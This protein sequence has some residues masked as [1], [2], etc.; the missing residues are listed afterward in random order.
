MDYVQAALALYE[1]YRNEENARSM[2]KYMRDQFKFF[3]M[4][5]PT[6]RAAEKEFMARCGLPA[7]DQWLAVLEELWNCE[8]REMQM[9]GLRMLDKKKKAFRKED[10]ALIELVLNRKVWWDTVDHTSKWHAGAYLMQFEAEKPAI[11]EKWLSSP[12]KWEVRAAILFQ[13][14]Y[15]G[16]T[17]EKILYENIRRHADSKEFFIAKAIGWALRE[18]AYTNPESVYE[19][20]QN[21]PMQPLSKRE[22]LKH[23]PKDA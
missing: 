4:R 6:M 11:L 15:K 22:A 17:Y 19:F 1:Q 3:G 23:F 2:E 8:E 12:N 10:L 13:L 20:V 7:D 9:L 21:T 14:G 18:Y 5:A 16:M